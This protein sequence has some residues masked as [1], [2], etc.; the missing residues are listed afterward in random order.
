[1]ESR[2]SA[3]THPTRATSAERSGHLAWTQDNAEKRSYRYAAS[4]DD[5]AGFERAW[6]EATA[7][8][9]PAMIHVRI[10]PGS[11]EKLGRPT[12][13]PDAVARRFKA[14]LAR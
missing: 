6:S 9:G 13:T 2:L 14:F 4:C 12:V 7:T 1:M 8:G 3:S 10:A 5:L 11:I